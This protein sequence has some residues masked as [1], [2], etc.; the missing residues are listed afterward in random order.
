MLFRSGRV[1]QA[2]VAG[3]LKSTMLFNPTTNTY[4]TGPTCVGIHNES[5]WL[6]LRDESILMVDRGATT[7]ERYRP[8]TGTWVADA[9][10]PVSL[11]DPYGLET[12][13]AVLLPDGRGFFGG[14]L[15]ATGFYT[16]GVGGANGTWAAGPSM[17]NSTGTP[18]APMAPL[19]NGKILLAVSPVPT[20][21]N[22]FPTPTTFWEFDPTALTYTQVGAPG[23]GTSVNAAAYTFNFICL[24]DGTV[25]CS[26]QG[27]SS[28]WAYV[29]DGS[30]LA[31]AKPVV[32][33][34]QRATTG[35]YTIT[36]LQLN[37]NNEGASYG[38][39]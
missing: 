20:S 10:V 23:G 24:P 31:A 26:R 4:S 35:V 1:L 32:T 13:G 8:S 30:P 16:P 9:V 11:Y 29:P 39:D 22:H 33:L 36:G 2:I 3:T 19:T 18:D 34:L 37:G 28:Y 12:G 17:P 27:S 15:G 25:L 6:K 38:D 5:V 7:S 21:A 14:S